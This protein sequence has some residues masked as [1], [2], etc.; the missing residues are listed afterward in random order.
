MY[1]LYSLLPGKPEQAVCNDIGS[2]LQTDC[3]SRLR[4]DRNDGGALFKQIAS[5]VSV[6]LQRPRNDAF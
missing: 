3:F 4:R 5:S 1:L 2:W 6:T